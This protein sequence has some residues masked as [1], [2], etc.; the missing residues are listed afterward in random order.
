MSLKTKVTYNPGM[1]ST[2]RDKL[3][4]NQFI[5][6]TEISPPKGVDPA[7]ALE[8]AEFVRDY[9]DAFNITDNQRAVMRMSPLA[10]G[11]LLLDAGHEVIM[12]LTCR[13][14]NRLALQSD[15][16]GAYGLG[17]RNICLMTGDY[18]T[19][20]DHPGSK[21]VYDLDAVQLLQAVSRMENGKD[22][23]GN[24]L[25]ST[26]VF[27]KG[28]VCNTDPENVM[29]LVKLEKKARVG[30]D[31]LQTQAVYDVGRFEDFVESISHLEVPILAGLIPLKSVKMAE[32]MNKN[33]PGIKVDNELIF[34][35]ESSEDPAKEGAL[36]CAEHIRELKK[37]CRGIHLM[38]VGNNRSIPT[39]LE[40]SGLY[41]K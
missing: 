36:I 14:R 31:F 4:S 30:L 6:T 13:D 26:P 12:Q 16:L 39:I 20:G 9:V 23:A 21:P 24:S 17:V 10:M 19:K 15:L 1:T 33:V 25:E 22:M 28:A 41:E 8:D 2:F 7:S 40:L 27:V 32:F 38:P 5:I 3:N 29:Q 11:K 35:L 34:R 37:I 18:P